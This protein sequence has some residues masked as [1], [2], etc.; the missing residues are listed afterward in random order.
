MFCIQ[1]WSEPS[2]QIRTSVFSSRRMPGTPGERYS[3]TSDFKMIGIDLFLSSQKHT[4]E[5]NTTLLWQHLTEDEANVTGSCTQPTAFIYLLIY[6]F[7]SSCLK[8][9]KKKKRFDTRAC[10]RHV[11]PFSAQQTSPKIPAVTTRLQR[12]AQCNFP[13]HRLPFWKALNDRLFNTVYL[14]L[15]VEPPVKA[16]F[17]PFAK[18]DAHVCVIV[19]ALMG[20]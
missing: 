13:Q 16:S 18:T 20:G 10:A 1:V 4:Q 6:F 12:A 11:E 17:Y 15:S 19:A 8:Q 3:Q 2:W 7:T 14:A 9:V 5:K